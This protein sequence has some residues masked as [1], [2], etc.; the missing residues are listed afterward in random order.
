MTCMA[1]AVII[2]RDAVVLGYGAGIRPGD[3]CYK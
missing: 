3:A 1:D 2:A